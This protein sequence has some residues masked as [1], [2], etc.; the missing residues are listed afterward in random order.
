[1]YKQASKADFYLGYM[2]GIEKYILEQRKKNI[3]LF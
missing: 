2:I 1:V 3:F